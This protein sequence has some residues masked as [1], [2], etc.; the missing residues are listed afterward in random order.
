MTTI[1]RSFKGF[2]G[3]FITSPE[4]N[5][6]TDYYFSTEG[7]GTAESDGPNALS[8]LLYEEDTYWG[9][10]AANWA[11]M[12]QTQNYYG[13]TGPFA[14][15][16]ICNGKLSPQYVPCLTDLLETKTSYPEAT[17][18]LTD[19]PWVQTD[20]T[21]DDMSRTNGIIFSNTVYHNLL[22]Q[23]TTSSDAPTVTQKWT[24]Q[25]T[26]QADSAG[27]YYYDVDKPVSSEIDDSSGHVWNCTNTTYDEKNTTG[28][29]TPTA[30]WPTTST[31]YSN[32][33]NKS[34]TAIKSY[35]GYDQYGNAVASVDPF[36][37]RQPQ[38][39]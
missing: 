28:L 33:T 34:G 30:G 37:G 1:T 29:T 10:Q 16:N 23:V 14:G 26:D 22:Q 35:I 20:Y 36:R 2:N 31:A 5:L 15:M 12:R 38:P 13:G 21:Y 25:T 6:T 11:L 39:L 32:C 27:I 8:G 24:Y 4:G 17:G 3:V 18:D 7:W 9:N 19:A